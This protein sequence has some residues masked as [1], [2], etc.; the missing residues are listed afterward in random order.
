[1]DTL[2]L[3]KNAVVTKT[4]SAIYATMQ[5]GLDAR[6]T[7]LQRDKVGAQERADIH[8]IA[9]YTRQNDACC[10]VRTTRNVTNHLLRWTVGASPVDPI[11]DVPQGHMSRT[12]AV[13]RNIATSGGVLGL[14][15]DTIVSPVVGAVACCVG[16]LVG[17]LRGRLSRNEGK[18]YAAVFEPNNGSITGAIAGGGTGAAAVQ[19][20]A[21]GVG[22]LLSTT[23]MIVQMTLMVLA[24]GVGHA[25]G[26]VH[27]HIATQAL[28]VGDPLVLPHAD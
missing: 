24:L 15:A 8:D 1:M 26:A 10:L 20:V 27:G 22:A 17:A 7:R 2:A 16:T 14:L 5:G 9:R 23:G 13:M 6:I 12:A 11:R 4:S 18:T 28:R 19:L 3:L 25:Y 21:H